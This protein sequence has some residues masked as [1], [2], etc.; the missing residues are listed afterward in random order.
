MTHLLWLVVFRT[1]CKLCFHLDH[2]VRV[3]LFLQPSK[4]VRLYRPIGVEHICQ[5]MWC[6]M[7]Q[8]IL[9]GSSP[10]SIQGDDGDICLFCRSIDNEVD[11]LRLIKSESELALMRICGD[12]TAEMFADSMPFSKQRVR[13]PVEVAE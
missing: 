8:Y 13:V 9:H 3:N 10:H 4:I 1:L 5:Q 12:I 6:V 7:W 11:E 2:S